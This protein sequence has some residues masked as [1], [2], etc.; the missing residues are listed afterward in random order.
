MAELIVILIFSV[1]LRIVMWTGAATDD[2]VHLWCTKV[3]RES[4]GFFNHRLNDSVVPGSL[5]YPTLAHGIIS[6]FPRPAW[7]LAG[8]LLNIGYDCIL[9]AGT[10]I[11]G[12]IALPSNEG[13][14]L[15]PA[16]IA[17]FA[18]ATSPALLPITARMKS[19]GARGIGNLMIQVYYLCLWAGMSTGSPAFAFAG[20][21]MGLVVLMTSKFALQV[22][23]FSTPVIALLSMSAYP[24]L[25]L[26]L[27]VAAS[28]IAY[29][30]KVKGVRDNIE[31]LIEH[32]SWYHRNMDLGTGA[33]MR[34]R[35]SDLLALPKFWKTN[36]DVFWGVLFRRNSYVIALY[37][38]PLVWFALWG[39][40]SSS[41]QGDFSFRFMADVVLALAVTMLVISHP[42]LAFVGQAERYLEYAVPAGA[43]VMSWL[44]SEGTVPLG[45]VFLVFIAQLTFVCAN[46][47]YVNYA[48]I[49]TNLAPAVGAEVSTYINGREGLRVLTIPMKLSFQLAALSEAANSFYYKFSLHETR[50]MKHRDSEM[51]WMDFP[52][53]DLEFFNRE[54][55]VNALVVDKDFLAKRNDQGLEYDLSDWQPVYEDETH[56]LYEYRDGSACY[57]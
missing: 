49:R 25:V 35:L 17:A 40:F 13:F 21:A 32:T 52:R 54:Y 14:P 1:A 10:W 2:M 23:L 56:I 6:L 31:H 15:A 55:G 4:S 28:I 22:Y 16:S 44:A 43:L 30:L 57:A 18:V 7:K 38:F 29:A 41:F 19:L 51:P 33:M 47:A 11:A 12:S 42:K 5:G 20:A 36:K 9:V 53:T 27:F 3:R 48:Q 24:L 45:L 34:N 26:F 8:K 46:V 39:I 50:G 37:S